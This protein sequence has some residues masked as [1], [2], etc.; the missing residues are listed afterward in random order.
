MAGIE[1][2]ESSQTFLL[3]TPASSYALSCDQ[4]ASILRHLHWGA[5]IDLESAVAIG[6]ASDVPLG[7]ERLT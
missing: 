7:G 2:D 6:R 5:P 1:L 4:E 3:T